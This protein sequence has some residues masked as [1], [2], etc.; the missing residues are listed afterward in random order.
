ML[1]SDII[2]ADGNVRTIDD[3][4]KGYSLNMNVLIT[5]E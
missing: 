4:R 5:S 1:V 2:N 3:L